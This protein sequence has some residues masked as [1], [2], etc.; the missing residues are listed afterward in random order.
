MFANLLIF[1][2]G[3]GTG[4]AS[5]K[6]A[7]DYKDRHL[8]REMSRTEQYRAQYEQARVSLA[9]HQGRAGMAVATP[10]DDGYAPAPIDLFTEED[11]EALNNGR[12]VVRVR[13]GGAS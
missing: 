9:Y 10:M 1:I 13:R 3:I 2:L 12:R 6:A 5:M 7:V 4:L 11:Q 8:R